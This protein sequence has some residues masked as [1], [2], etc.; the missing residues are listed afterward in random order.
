MSQKLLIS[1]TQNCGTPISKG[2]VIEC[3]CYTDG[4][5]T[6]LTVLNVEE[7]VLEIY[8]SSSNSLHSMIA[9]IVLPHNVVLCRTDG[10]KAGNKAS[11]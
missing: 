5:H 11:N 1:D 10:N 3:V 4:C 6:I 2:E 7:N 8:Q 9:R